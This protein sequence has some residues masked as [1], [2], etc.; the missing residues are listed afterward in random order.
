MTFKQLRESNFM[1]QMEV[2]S[3]CGV[4]ITTV[5]N[6]ERGEQQPRIFQIRRLAELFKITPQEVQSAVDATAIEKGKA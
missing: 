4:T 1:T 2:A 5:S 6:W 3:F